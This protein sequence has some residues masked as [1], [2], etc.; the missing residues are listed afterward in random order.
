M[1]ER[2]PPDELVPRVAW[3][4]AKRKF[5]KWG[6]ATID[7]LLLTAH[8]TFLYIAFLI[9]DDLVLAQ[10]TRSFGDLI[11][12]SELAKTLLR[13]TKIVSA[14]GTA[15]AYTLHLVYSLYLQARHVVKTLK[16]SEEAEGT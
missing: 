10:I 15:V 14:L 1:P 16:K 12:Q 6:V 7:P 2:G 13:W 9:A 3:E 11:N 4:I 8:L 5:L